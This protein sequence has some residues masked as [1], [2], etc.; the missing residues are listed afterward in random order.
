MLTF[1]QGRK[2]ARTVDGVGLVLYGIGINFIGLD[3]ELAVEPV[4]FSTSFGARIQPNSFRP[5][6][7]WLLSHRVAAT[8]P[9]SAD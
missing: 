2:T 6:H 4:F 7:S 3:W 9:T 8:F 1:C 5:S